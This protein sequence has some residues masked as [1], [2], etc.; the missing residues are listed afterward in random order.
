MAKAFYANV[1]QACA[2][3]MG[4]YFPRVFEGAIELGGLYIQLKLRNLAKRSTTVSAGSDI[5]G[6]TG[7]H[8]AP[9]LLR[10]VSRR[11]QIV[12]DNNRNRASGTTARFVICYWKST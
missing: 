3:F 10:S 11:L 8:F 4:I 1:M 9:Y 6:D 2:T 12:V 5:F 7:E